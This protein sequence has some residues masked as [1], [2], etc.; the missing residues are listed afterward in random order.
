VA[1]QRNHFKEPQTV[2]MEKMEEIVGKPENLTVPV[3]RI[4]IEVK[5]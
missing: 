2:K 3:R 5:A 4:E 1:V